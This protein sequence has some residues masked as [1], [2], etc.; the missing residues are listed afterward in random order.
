MVRTHLEPE[1]LWTHPHAAEEGL[2]A[3]EPPAGGWGWSSRESRR[4]CQTLGSRQEAAPGVGDAAFTDSTSTTDKFPTDPQKLTLV[5]AG[6]LEPGKQRGPRRAP[7]GRVLL[8]P[9]G[10]KV[11]TEERKRRKRGAQP[12][13]GA[14]WDTRRRA[15][16]H[17]RDVKGAHAR[18]DSRAGP[19]LPGG[20]WRGQKGSPTCS[21]NETVERTVPAGNAVSWEQERRSIGHA[22]Q[23]VL[24][25]ATRTAWRVGC[26]GTQSGTR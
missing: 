8:R 16:P 25:T 23:G 22:S 21:K 2:G 18:E 12:H 6:T 24:G 15:W 5:P 19:R 26:W 14:W 11:R 20:P 4:F 1:R 3:R 9:W 13:R 7:Q 17:P 10:P